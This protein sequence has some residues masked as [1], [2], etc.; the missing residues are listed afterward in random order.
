MVFLTP[1]SPRHRRLLPDLPTPLY[2]SPVVSVPGRL[3]GPL[4]VEGVAA[5][6]AE[7]GP[8]QQEAGPGAGQLLQEAEESCQLVRPSRPTLTCPTT[9]YQLP[10]RTVHHITSYIICTISMIQYLH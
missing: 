3:P 2:V 8:G 9:N 5:G 4:P 7:D 1:I 6:G 10:Q